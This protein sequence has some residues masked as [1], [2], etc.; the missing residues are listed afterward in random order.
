M[1]SI[2]YE[3]L[4]AYYT[5]LEANWSE[6]Q[7]AAC[8]PFQLNGN[9]GDSSAGLKIMFCRVVGKLLLLTLGYALMLVT[10]TF[11]YAHF[12]AVVSGLAIGYGLFAGLGKR[13]AF[14]S[15]N[16]AVEMKVT[17]CC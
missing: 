12:F 16:S 8:W 6:T 7:S 17:A 3:F 9:K 14:K 4:T 15:G 10:M 1:L 5:A 11:N 13:A 2:L